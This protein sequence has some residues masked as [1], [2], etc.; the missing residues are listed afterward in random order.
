[1][2]KDFFRICENP[3]DDL[4]TCYIILG[5]LPKIMK[6]LWKTINSRTFRKNPCQVFEDLSLCLCDK[7]NLYIYV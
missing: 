4:S 6:A 7:E 2:I 1:M 5:V 3:I